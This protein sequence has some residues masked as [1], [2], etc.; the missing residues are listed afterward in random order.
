MK[1]TIIFAIFVLLISACTS[2]II[3]K[4][5]TAEYN[6][7]IN[8]SEFTTNIT[9]KYFS[10]PI[11]TKFVYEAK[12]PEGTERNEILITNQ[13]KII[14][15][16]TTLIYWDRVWL[17][18]EL[19]EDTRD[20]LA[21][22]AEGNLW[23][24]GEDV[25]NYVDG[26]LAD[27]HGSWIAGVDGAKPG[28]WMKQNPVVGET[29]RQEHY[30]GEAEDMADV[31]SLTETVTVPYGTFTNCLKTKDYTPLDPSAIEYKYYCPEIS[32]FVLE[33][34]PAEGE[35]VELISIT[36]ETK[37]EVVVPQNVET[38]QKKITEEDAKLIAI[39]EV[40][41]AFIDIGIENKYGKLVYVVE[42]LVDGVETDVVIDIDTGKI[43]GIEK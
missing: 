5:N 23:Y 3:V 7:Q 19:I 36:S 6:P 27:H 43:L 17:N 22:D 33:D 24:F 4:E 9:N 42:M 18:G 35:R 40:G 1:G 14:M 15:G 39:K 32:I 12:L 31:L 10:L 16:V 13:T 26:K 41:G 20:Y 2:E 29:Y 25:D 8:P 37:T 38:V 11:G 28:I 34:I 30:L 21:Q